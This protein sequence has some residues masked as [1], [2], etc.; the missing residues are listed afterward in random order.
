[1]EYDEVK[2][3]KKIE[4]KLFKNNKTELFYK[5]IITLGATA[6]ILSLLSFFNIVINKSL[7]LES[8]KLYT[9]LIVY[10]MIVLTI[11]NIELE[12]NRYKL[13]ENL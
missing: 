11:A 3:I 8:I 4:R 9:V 13:V 6:L 7:T 5:I 10:S 12:K 1:M 2:E